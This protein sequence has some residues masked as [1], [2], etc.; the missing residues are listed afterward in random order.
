MTPNPSLNTDARKTAAR[1]LTERNRG[2]LRPQFV[3]GAEYYWRATLT[4]LV[5][6]QL[7]LGNRGLSPVILS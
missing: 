3:A 5:E 1:R 4:D 6:A 7:R 2:Q